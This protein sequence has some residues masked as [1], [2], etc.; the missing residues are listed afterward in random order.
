MYERL[1]DYIRATKSTNHMYGIANASLSAQRGRNCLCSR[2]DPEAKASKLKHA[3]KSY[4]AFETVENLEA[5]DVMRL[6]GFDSLGNWRA[7]NRKSF[8]GRQVSPIKSSRD[9]FGL[10]F[11]SGIK[12]RG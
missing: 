7:Y 5:T 2:T 8:A 6:I 9:Y 11:R 3:K 1:A 4:E 10:E 12:R